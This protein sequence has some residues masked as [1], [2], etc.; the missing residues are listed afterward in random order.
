MSRIFKRARQPGK[1]GG[2]LD[3]WYVEWRDEHGRKL[4]RSAGPSRRNAER[5]LALLLAEVEER[6]RLGLPRGADGSTP[7]A[8]FV[9]EYLELRRPALKSIRSVSNR[10]RA[11]SVEFGPHAR[12]RDVTAHRVEAFRAKRVASGAAPA[13]VNREVANLKTLLF[14]AMRWGRLAYHPLAQVRLL[15]EEN[16]RTRYLTRQEAE[17]FVAAARREHQARTGRA[18]LATLI[19]LALNTGAR[20]GDLLR[21]RWEHVDLQR[22]LLTFPKTKEGQ[23][24][25]VPMNDVV[26]RELSRAPRRDERVFGAYP[27]REFRRAREAAGLGADVVFHSLRHTAITWMAEAGVDPRVI[28]Q[29]VGHATLAMTERYTHLGEA[30]TRHAVQQLEAGALLRA[31]AGGEEGA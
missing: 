21:L 31:V 28:Q 7:F 24:R 6:R 3:N 10:L 25:R 11:W 19:V 4:S 16:R 12:L 20:R 5:M 1:G 27:Q 18:S 8:E 29:V 22:R 13:T 26:F 14:C 23:L 9:E 17:A 2:K 15:R 30:A